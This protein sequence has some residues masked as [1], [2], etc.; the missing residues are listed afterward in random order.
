MESSS[1]SSTEMGFSFSDGRLQAKI[2]PIEQLR[3]KEKRVRF[4]D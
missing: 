2:A 1:R 3:K 4:M